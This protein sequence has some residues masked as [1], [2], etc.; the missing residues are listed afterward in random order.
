M[1]KLLGHFESV[2]TICFGHASGLVKQSK[3]CLPCFVDLVDVIGSR[4]LRSR[5]KRNDR[6]LKS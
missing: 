3:N 4:S 6:I 1:G 5:C 2:L